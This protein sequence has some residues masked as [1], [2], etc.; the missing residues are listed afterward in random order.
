MNRQMLAHFASCALL[1][2]A[3]LWPLWFVYP[4]GLA[5]LVASGGLLRN[6]LSALSVH[7]EHRL[8]IKSVICNTRR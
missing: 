3:V 2:L 7:R 5:L 6:L 8:K 4:A 1:L